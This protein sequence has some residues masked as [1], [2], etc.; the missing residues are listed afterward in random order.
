MFLFLSICR[1]TARMT[2]EEKE[3]VERRGWKEADI[4]TVD[5]KRGRERERGGGAG[6]KVDGWGE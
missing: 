1:R 2:G 4:E 6:E 3:G 5:R